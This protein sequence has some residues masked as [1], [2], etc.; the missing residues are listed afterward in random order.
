MRPKSP[1]SRREVHAIISLLLSA[2]ATPLSFACGAAARGR[3]GRG[4]KKGRGRGRKGAEESEG[5]PEEAE[6][7]HGSEAEGSDAEKAAKGRAADG[8]AGATPTPPPPQENGKGGSPAAAA[9]AA[10]T[11]AG[12]GAAARG[13]VDFRKSV[14]RGRPLAVAAPTGASK[15]F[16]DVQDLFRAAEEVRVA[17]HSVSSPTGGLLWSG[18]V[19]FWEAQLCGSASVS[20]PRGKNHTRERL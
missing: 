7:V 18:E 5:E 14:G 15:A 13:P 4:A 12:A 17:A 6:N 11:A 19:V 1:C 10:A 16:Q 9:A 8:D 2:L 20:A 3:G